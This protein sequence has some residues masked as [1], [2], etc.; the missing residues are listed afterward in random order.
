MLNE[1][2]DEVL[3]MEDTIPL[4]YILVQCLGF[5]IN[6]IVFGKNDNFKKAGYGNYFSYTQH[7]LEKLKQY[8]EHLTSLLKINISG[9][10]NFELKM[11]VS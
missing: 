4:V 2:D 8:V 7:D 6:V 11:T 1:I 10:N 9:D 3:Q 5:L